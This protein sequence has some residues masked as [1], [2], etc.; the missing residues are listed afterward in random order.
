MMIE[1]VNGHVNIPDMSIYSLL[2]KNAEV[3]GS[4]PVIIFYDKYITYAKLLKY[5]D[6]MAYQLEH[7]LNVRKGDTIGI[8]MDYSPQYVISIISSMKIG[9]RILI[10]DGDV[11][12][13]IVNAYTDKYGINVM[14][15][16]KK[17]AEKANNERIKYIVS[18]TLK[19]N[20]L[21]SI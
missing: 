14:I 2:Q 5:V 12:E 10:I 19:A 11:D 20:N 13:K 9:A 4:K 6:S 7:L 3:N 16:C 18:F 17:F 21:P 8:L 1:A 15:V